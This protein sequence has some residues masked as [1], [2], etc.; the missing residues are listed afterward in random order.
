MLKVLEKFWLV[1]TALSFFYGIYECFASGF[2]DGLLLFAISL[3]SALKYFLS[4]R[5]NLRMEKDKLN[6]NLGA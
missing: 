1:V 4:R 6:K 3:I 2:M 5:R